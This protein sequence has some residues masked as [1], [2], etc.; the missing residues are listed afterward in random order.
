MQAQLVRFFEGKQAFLM[1]GRTNNLAATAV[2]RNFNGAKLCFIEKTAPD[3]FSIKKCKIKRTNC[4]QKAELV[5][6]SF[7]S[8]IILWNDSFVVQYK[9]KK[10]RLSFSDSLFLHWKYYCCFSLT[11]IK[12]LLIYLPTILGDTFLALGTAITSPLT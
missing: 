12:P 10:K 9:Y 5:R 3:G 7:I 1:L 4:T 11:V 6:I 2:D 8:N